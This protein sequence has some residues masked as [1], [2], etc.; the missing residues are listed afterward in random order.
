[1]FI[2]CPES[3]LSDAEDVR[4]DIFLDGEDLLLCSFLFGDL[5]CLGNELSLLLWDLLF[6]TGGAPFLSEEWECLSGDLLFLLSLCLRGD[7]LCDK[8][9]FLGNG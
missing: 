3:R 2:K 6:F 1:M 4:C 7:G 5:N 8:F 9:L